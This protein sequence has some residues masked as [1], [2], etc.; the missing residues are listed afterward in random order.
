MQGMA[1]TPIARPRRSATIACEVGQAILYEGDKGA[2]VWVTRAGHITI[3]NPLRPLTPDTTRVLQLV[4]GN[5]T[6]TA[7]GADWDALRRGGA[8]G[9]LEAQIGGPIRWDASLP[10]LPDALNIV[11]DSGASLTELPFKT[12]GE[13]PAVR[14]ASAPATK[15][16]SATAGAPSAAAKPNP[17][18]AKPSRV[19]N[20][21]LPE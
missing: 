11:A 6:A 3:D 16:S 15:R 17:R 14:A 12:C 13:A 2:S 10:A 21:A 7:Y 18:A 5:R 1:Q 20:G 4:I 9:T 19:P 8:P